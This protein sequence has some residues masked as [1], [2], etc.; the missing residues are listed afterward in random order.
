MNRFSNEPNVI[1]NCRS[2]FHLGY[3]YNEPIRFHSMSVGSLN[4]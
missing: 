2:E 3:R 1:T 4:R